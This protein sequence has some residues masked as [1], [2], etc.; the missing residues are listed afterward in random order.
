MATVGEI[1][2]TIKALA[3]EYSDELAWGVR[4]DVAGLPVG[5]VFPASRVWVDGDPTDE[6]LKG[7]CAVSVKAVSSK[8]IYP[9]AAYI[10]C[11][12]RE[13]GETDRG[14]VV[15]S[16]CEVMALVD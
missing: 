3:D 16:E 14:E 13:T 7:T 5:H 15:L 9:G 2:N 12:Y 8:S 4:Y 10:V 1:R 6:L 11:G